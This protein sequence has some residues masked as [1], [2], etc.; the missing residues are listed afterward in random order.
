MRFSDKIERSK[1]TGSKIKGFFTDE[2][3]RI[4]LL[5]FAKAKFRKFFYS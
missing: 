5:L 2:W 3:P 4:Y 1:D